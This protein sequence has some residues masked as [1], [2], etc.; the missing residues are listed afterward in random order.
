[1]V[2][3]VNAPL[4]NIVNVDTPTTGEVIVQGAELTSG[5]EP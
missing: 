5:S 3:N 4:V 2:D 1:V